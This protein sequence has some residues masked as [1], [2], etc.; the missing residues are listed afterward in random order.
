VNNNNKES[1]NRL[2]RRRFLGAA[3]KMTAI[4]GAV[5]ANPWNALG[6]QSRRVN[7]VGLQLYS[8]RAEMGQSFE[9]TLEKLAEIGFKE[10]EFAGYF[11]KSPAEVKT[12]LD[13]FGLTSPAA[14]IQL[15]AIRQN[16]EKE[17]ETAAT[18]GQKYIVVPSL[19]ANERTLD[20]YLAHAETLNRA[21]EAA[22]AAGIKMG[23][24]NHSF[25]FEP[26]N[27][28]KL[29][30]DYLLELTEPEL[31]DMEMDLF[32]IINAKQ[33]P[34]TYFQNH[35]GRFSNL[36]VKDMAVGGE[37]TDVGRGTIDFARL[38]SHAEDAGFQHYFIEHDN[39]DDGLNSIA[40]SFN[41]VDNIRF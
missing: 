8:L 2:S 34:V 22:K 12:I 21:G 16:L 31:V 28:G 25:E 4:A 23:Y 7:S 36:H 1:R 41:S 39:P 10:M 29:G 27:N 18:I 17:I 40:Y 24:H 15:N 13:R 11:D 6:A 5:A 3:L 33:D 9:G 14:H 20:D 30:Y 32:W 19:P 26:L 38:F 35:P 37:M